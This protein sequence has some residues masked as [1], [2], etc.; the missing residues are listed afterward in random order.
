MIDHITDTTQ[1]PTYKSLKLDTEYEHEHEHKE[2]S[3]DLQPSTH[4][5]TQHN[6]P[7]IINTQHYNQRVPARSDSET[8]SV[9]YNQS[10]N[11]AESVTSSTSQSSVSEQL[12]ILPH[13]VLQRTVPVKQRPKPK[14]FK[15]DLY[16]ISKSLNTAP[17]VRNIPHWSSFPEPK[18]FKLSD[19]QAILLILNKINQSIIDTH[20]N[21]IQCVNQDT[22]HI[23]PRL[24]V[25]DNGIASLRVNTNHITNTNISIT[26]NNK[27]SAVVKLPAVESTQH[28]HSNAQSVPSNCCSILL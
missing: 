10:A 15:F 22:S 4:N 16:D 26:S 11:S 25:A 9:D 12:T 18:D 23:K 14:K 13:T 27:Q 7:A 17:T 8:S 28:Y 24:V 5:T 21:T 2:Q 6:R 20:N 3:I 19:R 1:Y